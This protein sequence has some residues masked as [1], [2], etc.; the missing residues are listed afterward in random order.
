M[1]EKKVNHPDYYNKGR[2]EVIDVI[3]AF[4][5]DFHLGNV[6]KYILRSNFKNNYLDDLKKARWYLR[7]EIRNIKKVKKNG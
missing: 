1:S 5:L 4:K 6:I 2:I 3:E 7:R